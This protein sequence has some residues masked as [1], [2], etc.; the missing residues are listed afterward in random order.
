MDLPVCHVS[1]SEGSSW[2]FFVWN[3]GKEWLFILFDYS[4]VLAIAKGRTKQLIDLIIRDSIAYILPGWWFQIFVYFHH[5]LGRIPILTNIFERAWFNH[6]LDISYLLF[7]R[8]IL[9]S[10]P[11]TLEDT[12]D[13]SPTV[14]EGISLFVGVWGSLGYLPRVCGQIHGMMSL[15]AIGIPSNNENQQGMG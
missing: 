3:Y 15:D 2:T 9:R 7:V 13:V 12:P 14:Y 1:V 5:Y 10:H 8:M 6:Q 4:H 11:H